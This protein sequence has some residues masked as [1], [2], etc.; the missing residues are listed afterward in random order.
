MPSE[1]RYKFARLDRPDLDSAIA[2]SSDDALRVKLEAIY[3]VCVTRN[4]GDLGF[5]RSPTSVEFESGFIQ[6]TPVRSQWCKAG[7]GCGAIGNKGC[8]VFGGDGFDSS[9]VY[10]P[11]FLSGEDVAPDG[12][13]F[14]KATPGLG[15]AEACGDGGEIEETQDVD[16]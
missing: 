2:R 15:D 12:V 5:A 11:A 10:V 8:P 13:V 4:P 9:K 1:G 3:A 16:R 6:F 7:N 14:G